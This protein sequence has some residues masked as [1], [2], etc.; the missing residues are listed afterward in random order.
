M[1]ICF[2]LSVFYIWSHWFSTHANIL[3]KRTFHNLWYAHTCAY[4]GVRNA[5]FFG[6]LCVHTKRMIPLYFYTLSSWFHATATWN[7]GGLD[8]RETFFFKSFSCKFK[9]TNCYLQKGTRMWKC[10]HL[11]EYVE[12]DF[13]FW[14]ILTWCVNY[15]KGFLSH[16]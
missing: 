15:D 10:I 14:K 11:R 8:Q 2:F 13:N 7:F 9:E 6:K 16:C 4:Q 1:L 5:S 12:F 3:E